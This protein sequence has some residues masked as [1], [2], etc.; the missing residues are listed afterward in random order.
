MDT[1]TRVMAVVGAILVI[2]GVADIIVASG[3]AERAAEESLRA[4]AANLDA[5]LAA[6]GSVH[7]HQFLDSGLPL[8][9]GTLGFLPDHAL[10]RIAKDFAARTGGEIGIAVASDNLSL[11]KGEVSPAEK[12]AIAHF[13][14]NPGDPPLFAPD[15][16][17]YLYARPLWVDAYCL[18]CHGEGTKAPQELRA[19]TGGGFDVGDFRGL[20]VIR[21]P[22]D[23]VSTEKMRAIAFNIPIYGVALIAMIA[24]VSLVERWR[25][26]EGALADLRKGLGGGDP[27]VT[28]QP[29]FS[30]ESNRAVL[31]EALVRWRHPTRGMIR[32]EDFLNIVSSLGVALDLDRW[33]T[34]AACRSFAHWRG[35]GEDGLRL[36]LHIVPLG[37]EPDDVL[38]IMTKHGVRPGD[39]DVK[40]VIDPAPWA[41][42]GFGVVMERFDIGLENIRA[43]SI[44]GRL[45]DD[46]VGLDLIGS[47]VETAR[48]MGVEVLAR[49]VETPEQATALMELGCDCLSGHL[50]ANPTPPDGV[51]GVL[52]RLEGMREK[53]S[54]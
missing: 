3:E 35:G 30:P 13:T 51:P 53:L 5:A 17:G 31:L 1:K 43:M 28:F 11:A 50:I 46:E 42:A 18:T 33:V 37:L 23:A 38:E 14:R 6:T 36:L 25:G 8:R 48:G 39:V 15:G 27:V 2:L 4:Q 22:G 20:F 41:D 26:R 12:D 49:K 9:K 52:E 40:G 29:A 54:G 21:L 45:A 24:V 7:H 32:A 16:E 44:D 19:E 47:I 10:Q 34:D